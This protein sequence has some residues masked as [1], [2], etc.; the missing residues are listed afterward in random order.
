[1]IET[2][3]LLPSGFLWV[4]LKFHQLLHFT[5]Q[6]VNDEKK[7]MVSQNNA[8]TFLGILLLNQSG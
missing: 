6:G 5:N 1:V 3:F 8:I 7:Q 4:T 2:S